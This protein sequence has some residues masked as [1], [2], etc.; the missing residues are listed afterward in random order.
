MFELTERQYKNLLAE[1]SALQKRVG[2]LEAQF[3]LQGARVVQPA[4]YR[5]EK[6]PETA[7]AHMVDLNDFTSKFDDTMW[8]MIEVIGKE[9]FARYPDIERVFRQEGSFVETRLRRA[10]KGLTEMNIL[11]RT[12]LN[13]P[14]TPIT[15]LYSLSSIGDR[16]FRKQFKVAPVPS[17]MVKVIKEHDNLEHGYGILELGQL[18]ADSGTFKGVHVFNRSR[19]VRFN[20]GT[21]YIPDVMCI[22]HESNGRTY[23]EYERGNH[24]QK[25]FN[26]KCDK[27][28]IATR[29]LNFVAPNR[30]ALVNR[31][32]PLAKGWVKKKGCNES[33][34]IIIRL[35]TSKELQKCQ[36]SDHAWLVVFDLGQSVTPVV[37]EVAIGEP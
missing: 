19:P 11:T 32:Y 34:N 21:Q 36:L 25:D 30:K 23:F 24:T 6:T 33:S 10:A 4:I 20:N 1:L 3:D 22:E 14:L 9:G 37:C 29:Y 16:V 28:C 2:M 18:L 17:E 26:E 7:V 8:K 5:P 12:E 35:T 13:L 27:M 31:L 15:I